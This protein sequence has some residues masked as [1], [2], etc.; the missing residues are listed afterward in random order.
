MMLCERQRRARWPPVATLLHVRPRGASRRAAAR[1]APCTRQRMP[2]RLV[3]API[4]ALAARHPFRSLKPFPLASP[5]SGQPPVV[6]PLIRTNKP[7]HF[8]LLHSYPLIV[9]TLFKSLHL[10]IQLRVVLSP[11]LHFNAA[12]N[13]Q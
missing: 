1:A 13:S 4:V 8:Q 6:H 3:R 5:L 10:V 9:T 7:E 2:A 12:L 11:A